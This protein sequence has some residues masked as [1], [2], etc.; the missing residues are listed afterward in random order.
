MG[1]RAKMYVSEISYG[2]SGGK[3]TLIPVCRG[4]ENKSWS[5]AT[6]GGKCELS[7]LNPAALEWYKAILDGAREGKR[8]EVYVDFTDASAQDAPI[9]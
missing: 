3:V 2:T 6:P 4:E 5:A 8:P 7:I 9:A 1:V